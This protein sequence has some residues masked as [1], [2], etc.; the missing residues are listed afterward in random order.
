MFCKKCGSPIED[1]A[2][3]CKKCGAPTESSG[4]SSA[5]LSSMT[6]DVKKNHISTEMPVF[7]VLLLQVVQLILCF[8]PV[9]K[10]SIPRYG[11]NQSFTVMTGLNESGYFDTDIKAITFILIGLSIVGIILTILN[12][13]KIYIGELVSYI[14]RFI[15]WGFISFWTLGTWAVL[16]QACQ[17]M[18]YESQV[19]VKMSTNFGGILLHI[20]NILLFVSLIILIRYSGKNKN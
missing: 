19:I 12:L 7:M 13:L 6:A 1:N 17:E 10:I 3:F 18:Q 4:Q 20:V 11:E 9:F 5:P 2:K 15:S 16:T 8:L 14:I